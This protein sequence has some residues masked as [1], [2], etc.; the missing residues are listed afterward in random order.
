MADWKTEDSALKAFDCAA[1]LA[2]KLEFYGIN[3]E[4]LTLIQS[5]LKE[6]HQKALNDKI[7]ANDSVSSRWKKLQMGFLGVRSWVRYFFLF[8]LMIYQK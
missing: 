4:L 3:G 5:Y 8:I 1:I 2:H 7:N 6:R